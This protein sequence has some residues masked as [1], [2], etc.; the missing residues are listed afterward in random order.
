MRKIKMIG[1]AS[2]Q[3]PFQFGHTVF[4]DFVLAKMLASTGELQY[5]DLR[6][7][8]SQAEVDTELRRQA[9]A[10]YQAMADADGVDRVVTDD[11][12]TRPFIPPQGWPSGSVRGVV[13]A[14]QKPF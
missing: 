1:T 6:D 7:A 11:M 10:A 14:N 5:V 2:A 8:V 12:L 9:R 3:P 13:K 4:V